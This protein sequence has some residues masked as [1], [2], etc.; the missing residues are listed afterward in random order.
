VGTAPNEK[1]VQI[2]SG[3]WNTCGLHADGTVTCWGF[4]PDA[5]RYFQTNLGRHHAGMRRAHRRYG[6][7]LGRHGSA[8][9][10]GHLHSGLRRLLDRLRNTR[11]WR[12]RMLGRRPLRRDLPAD[13]RLHPHRDQRRLDVRVAPEWRRGL[14]GHGGDTGSLERRAGF[15]RAGIGGKSG[16]GRW[17]LG[18]GLCWLLSSTKGRRTNH[19]ALPLSRQR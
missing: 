15:S 14:L 3:E 11:G 6:H 8:G 10:V 9:S 13:R 18:R 4:G 7:L 19:V 1:F 5:G 17:A 16:R 2:S 12:R